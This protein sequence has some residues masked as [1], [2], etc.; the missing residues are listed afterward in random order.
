MYNAQAGSGTVKINGKKA[1]RKDDGTTH[2]GGSGN[3]IAGSS[4]VLTG[5]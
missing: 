5:G 3:S 2:C 4:D 1:H